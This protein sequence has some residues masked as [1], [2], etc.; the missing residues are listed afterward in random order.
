[1]IMDERILI[2]IDALD[3]YT[4]SKSEI[5]SVLRYY[6]SE[7]KKR[8]ASI[9]NL[10]TDS[11]KEIIRSLFDLQSE[12]SIVIYKYNYPVN[13]FIGN[14]I[15]DFDRQDEESVDFIYKKLVTKS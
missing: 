7:I 9:E 14:F 13:E 5:N 4:K 10:D 12:I 11:A 6:E 3:L 1:M 2:L 15:Y 8:L